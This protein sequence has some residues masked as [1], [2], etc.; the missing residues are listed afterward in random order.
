MLGRCSLAPSRGRILYYAPLISS[1]LLR[2][3]MQSDLNRHIIAT[4]AASCFL[5]LLSLNH[6]RESLAVLHHSFVLNSDNGLL[7][8]GALQPDVTRA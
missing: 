6:N 5:S 1:L 8:A 3:L 2:G 7:T 4:V